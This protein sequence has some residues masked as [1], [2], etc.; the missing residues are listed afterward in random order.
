MPRTSCRTRGWALLRLLADK[1]E[2]L[3]DGGQVLREDQVTAARKLLKV[4]A[5]SRPA[6]EFAAQLCRQLAGSGLNNAGHFVAEGRQ[7]AWAGRCGKVFGPRFQDVNDH[8]AEKF[9]VIDIRSSGAEILAR[10]T[11]LP[12]ASS[13]TLRSQQVR[14]VGHLP[15]IQASRMPVKTE[16]TSPCARASGCN[17]V[18][19]SPGKTSNRRAVTRSVF[20]QTRYGAADID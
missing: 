3:M 15:L 17:T 10:Q 19:G 7:V 12:P 11:A 16:K 20:D 1:F 6:G 4:C 2:L 13:S 14:G 9:K 18:A 5:G 8:P